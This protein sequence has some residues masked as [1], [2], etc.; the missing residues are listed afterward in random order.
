M[1]SEMCIRDS[2][3]SVGRIAFEEPEEAHAD[4]F[5]NQDVTAEMVVALG[6]ASMILGQVLRKGHN[7][8]VIPEKDR[9]K[10]VFKDG[11]LKQQAVLD[12]WFHEK[13]NNRWNRVSCFA[14]MFSEGSVEQS[15]QSSVD[16]RKALFGAIHTNMGSRYCIVL[17]CGQEFTPVTEPVHYRADKPGQNTFVRI[18]QPSPISVAC[19]ANHRHHSDLQ[20]CCELHHL[21]MV[22]GDAFYPAG[23]RILCMF[24]SV[25]ML[26][27]YITTGYFRDR[28]HR[29][30]KG[31][32]I[33]HLYEFSAGR[34]RSL[35]RM[36]SAGAHRMWTS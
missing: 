28:C 1:G 35:P 17:F 24:V 11:S 23:P 9:K 31:E 29:N 27:N 36:T 20:S 14:N 13:N 26:K 7:M 22:I 16:D 21:Y 19:A 32:F 5:K 4:H 3:R 12:G 25:T 6:R 10:I 33:K 2:Q 15:G 18:D 8:L 34:P 30:A